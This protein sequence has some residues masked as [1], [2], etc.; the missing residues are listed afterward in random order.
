MQSTKV[1]VL[2]TVLALCGA[3]SGSSQARPTV[4]EPSSSTTVS[5]AVIPEA[6]STP[7]A[8]C[9]DATTEALVRRFVAEFNAGAID[10]VDALFVPRGAGFRF[11]STQKWGVEI[12]RTRVLP[13]LQDFYQAGERMPDMRLTTV[14]GADFDG[15]G[16]A[17]ISY[18]VNGTIKFQIHCKTQLI[19]AIAWDGVDQ[20]ALR[21]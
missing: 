12:D 10:K 16:G 6:T 7:I 1:A 2:V 15:I 17:G 4:T 18:G 14:A 19:A 20:P 13:I 21:R 9:D 8:K 3:C 11:L 5:R